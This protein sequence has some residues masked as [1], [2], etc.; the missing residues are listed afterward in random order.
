MKPSPP[1]TLTPAAKKFWKEIALTLPEGHLRPADMPLFRQYLESLA[2]LESGR[3]AWREIGSPWTITHPNG[4]QGGHP[5]LA[6]IQRQA[7]TVTALAGKLRLCPS[8]RIS[9]RQ[10]GAAHHTEPDEFDNFLP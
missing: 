9:P 8:A 3:N 5:M 10:A 6:A 2:D 4:T 7:A 1:K